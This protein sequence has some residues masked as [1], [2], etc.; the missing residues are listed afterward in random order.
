MTDEE[1]SSAVNSIGLYLLLGQPQGAQASLLHAQLDENCIGYV[2]FD[3]LGTDV[4]C[5]LSSQDFPFEAILDLYQGQSNNHRWSEFEYFLSGADFKIKFLYADEVGV[6]RDS[7]E[8]REEML[9][10]YFGNKPV[11][12]PPFPGEDENPF[13]TGNPDGSWRAE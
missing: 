11:R 3:D 8:V 5:R 1:Y 2:V 13:Y 10:R 9:P 6:D 4:L 12:Y 7:F